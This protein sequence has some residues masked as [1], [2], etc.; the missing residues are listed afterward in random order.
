MRI[1]NELKVFT[2]SDCEYAPGYVIARIFEYISQR[3]KYIFILLLCIFAAFVAT[4]R[5][6]L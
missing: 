4:L 3:E 6:Q 2:L 5:A 1:W